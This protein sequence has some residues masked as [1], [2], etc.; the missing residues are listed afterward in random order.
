MPY[1]TERKDLYGTPREGLTGA[2]PVINSDHENIHTSKGFSASVWTEVVADDGV[3]LLEFKTPSVASGKY[4]HLKNY[5]A[6]GEGGLNTLE[7]IEAP[8]LTTGAAAVDAI[9]RNR[10]APT[11][12]AAT[13]KSNPTGIS[14]GTKIEQPFPFGGGGAGSGSG[15]LKDKDLEFQLAVNTTYLFKLTNLSGAAKALG[16][17]VFW[18]EE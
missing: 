7:I 14:A 15:G 17:W 18:Y 1:S 12:S 6:F 2:V 16:L 10:V 11:A 9:N 5:K 8:T 13:L 4:V 3:V